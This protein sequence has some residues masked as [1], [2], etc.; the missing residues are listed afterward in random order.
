MLFLIVLGLFCLVA[1]GSIMS[2]MGMDAHMEDE[3][4]LVGC[5]RG[6]G[7][8]LLGIAAYFIFFHHP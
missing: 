6:L 5:I 4:C 1:P 3:G 7:V 2:L 8:L